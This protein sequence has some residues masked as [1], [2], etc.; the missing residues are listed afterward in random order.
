V[1]ATHGQLMLTP[2]YAGPVCWSYVLT[3]YVG[4]VC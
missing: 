1:A 4:P 2:L 3:L